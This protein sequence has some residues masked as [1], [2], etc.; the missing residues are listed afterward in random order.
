MTADLL[1][2]Q[3]FSPFGG[4]IFRDL[5]MHNQKIWIEGRFMGHLTASISKTISC[6]VTYQLGLNI[7]SMRAFYKCMAR[8]VVPSSTLHKAKYVAFLKVFL[9][10]TLKLYNFSTVPDRG[11]YLSDKC[12]P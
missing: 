10:S 8:V 1:S 5:K 12:C 4:K 3:V 11:Y 6:S 2:G 7:S 9:A